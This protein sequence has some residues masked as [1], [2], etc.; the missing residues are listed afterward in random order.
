M[1][2]VSR[3]KRMSS[4][5]LSLMYTVHMEGTETKGRILG[6]DKTLLINIFLPVMSYHLLNVGLNA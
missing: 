5:K 3:M 6:I 4:F 2:N 1:Q